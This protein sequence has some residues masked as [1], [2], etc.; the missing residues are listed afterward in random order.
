[1]LGVLILYTLC[2]THLRP[3]EI[4]QPRIQTQG[5]FPKAQRTFGQFID[6]LADRFRT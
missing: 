3:D 5:W 4:I 1:M 6:L 2:D